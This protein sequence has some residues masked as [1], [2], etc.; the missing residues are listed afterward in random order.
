MNIRIRV[1]AAVLAGLSSVALAWSLAQPEA[2]SDEEQVR[3]LIQETYDVISGGIGVERDWQRM[4]DQCAEGAR[5]I[6]M[7]DS[8][9][10][11]VPLIWTVDDYIERAGPSLLR[12]GF[13]EKEI[14][15]VTEIYGDIAH[16]FSTYEGRRDDRPDAP[17]IRGVNSFQLVKV[18]GKWKVMTIL[19]HQESESTPIPAKY[20]P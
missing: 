17:P 11:S 7:I 10:G 2:P 5:M 9:D 1:A 4:R 6:P 14:H 16:V 8:P 13:H 12:V 19:W 20:L 18:K 3:A 15:A